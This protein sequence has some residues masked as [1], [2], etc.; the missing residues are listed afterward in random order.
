G[1]ISST[2]YSPC[3]GTSDL[4]ITYSVQPVENEDPLR[5]VWSL[6]PGMIPLGNPDLGGDT[7]TNVMQVRLLAD[8][9]LSPSSISVFNRNAYGDGP[10][11]TLNINIYKPAD[12]PSPIAGPSV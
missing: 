11:T 5:Y 12:T 3:L 4:I 2:N 8:S 6:G 9:P 7:R 1:T 10:A